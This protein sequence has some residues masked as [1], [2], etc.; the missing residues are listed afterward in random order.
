MF[1]QRKIV[2]ALS[3]HLKKRQ[4]TVIT[5]MRRTG[6]TSIV[7]QLLEDSQRMNKIYIDLERLDNRLLFREENYDHIIHA[8]EN[9]GIRMKEDALL[10]LDEIQLVPEITSVMKYLYDHFNVKFLV[11]G[12]SAFYLKNQFTESLAGRKKI[13]ELAP[14]D[15]GEFLSFKEVPYASQAPESLSFSENEY[16][17]IK[18][19]YDE[20]IN[21][22]GFPE[23]VLQQ[24]AEDKHD[25]LFDILGS[26]IHKDIKLLSDFSDEKHLFNLIRMLGSRVATRIDYTKISNLTGL[27]RHTV[28]HY[29]ELFEKSYLIDCIPVLSSRPET[30]IVKAQKLF[31]TDNGLL[32]ILADPGSGVLFENAVFN[33]LR[34]LGKINYYALKTGK[35][36]DFILN[37]KIAFEAKESPSAHDLRQLDSLSQKSGVGQRRLIGRYKVQGFKDFIWGGEIR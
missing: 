21:W 22:G 5:G 10:A 24:D 30:E 13:F 36:I 15:F 6:K 12:S 31:F 18:H 14:L 2:P 27:S 35:E 37:E 33:Q 9:R 19:W 29:M 25:L 11:T 7:K 20:F 32:R 34:H 26:Y 23:V 4:I 8:L 3:R 17:R 1:Y 28:T 16:N